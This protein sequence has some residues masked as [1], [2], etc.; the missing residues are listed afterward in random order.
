MNRRL[1]WGGPPASP[2]K[3]PYRDTFVVYGVLALIVVVVALLTGGSPGRA[4][5]VALLF[6]VAASAWN[7]YRLRARRR[8]AAE[9][10]PNTEEVDQP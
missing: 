8:R 2:T 3:N 9:S 6:F 4:V 5:I 10:E 7:V 1:E